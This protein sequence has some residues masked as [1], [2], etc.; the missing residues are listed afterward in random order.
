M[1]QGEHSAILSTVIKLPFVIQIVVLSVLSDRFRQFLLYLFRGRVHSVFSSFHNHLAVE[2]SGD[3]FT[4]IEF[5]L[6]CGCLC[7]VYHVASADNECTG[8]MCICTCY[9]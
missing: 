8:S 3:C 1:L 4:L 7:P 5:L 9:L 2:Q 6:P